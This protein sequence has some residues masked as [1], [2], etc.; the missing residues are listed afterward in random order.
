[1]I[2]NKKAK[3]E[4]NDVRRTYQRRPTDSLAPIEVEKK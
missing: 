4:K 3:S 1:M 2:D